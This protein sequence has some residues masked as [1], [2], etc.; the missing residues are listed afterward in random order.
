MI[1]G[2]PK[3]KLNLL[4]TQQYQ[5]G[6][7]NHYCFP[8]EGWEPLARIHSDNHLWL[9]MTAYHIVMEEGSL[10]YLDETVDFYDGGSATVWEHIQK[11]IDFTMANLG[12]RGFPLMLSSDWNDMLYKVCREGKGES[13]WTSMQF[14]TVLRQIAELAEPQRRRRAKISGYLCPAEK[15]CQ[16]KGV[17][18]RVVSSVHHG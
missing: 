1:P 12:E 9:V 11:S 5:D 15:A 7:C 6:H 4:F 13:I 14:G 17:G 16:R 18:R 3:D 10:D 2:G 8:T